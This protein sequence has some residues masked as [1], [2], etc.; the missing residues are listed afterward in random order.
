ML[1]INNVSK[2]FDELN[3]LDDVSF[4]VNEGEIVGLIGA[5][6]AGKST[7]MRIL[8]GVLEPDNGNALFDE[9]ELKNS[10]GLRRKIFFF[11]DEPFFAQ[12]STILEVA[13]LYAVFYPSFDFDV[14][15]RLCENL[16]LEPKS[17]I[18]KLSKG[19]KRQALIAVAVSI[20]PQFMFLDEVFDGVDSITKLT[21]KEILNKLSKEYN[22]TIITASHNIRE[23]EDICQSI[24]LLYKS[25]LVL[26]SELATLK[27][28]YASENFSLE[29]ILKCELEVY[30]YAKKSIDFI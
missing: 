1:T 23:I 3:A 18:S 28:K 9:K 24:C 11:P 25:K 22:T 26:F 6:G 8:A 5:N 17:K 7:L 14:F 2:S 16:E 29:E 15:H 20:R 10:I 4:Q 12:S 13:K 30:G 21:L 27:E 19:M